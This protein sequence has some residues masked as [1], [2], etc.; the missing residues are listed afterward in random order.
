MPQVL[1]IVVSITYSGLL[2]PEE[3]PHPA[4]QLMHTVSV[5]VIPAIR[6]RKIVPGL[7]QCALARYDDL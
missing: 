7:L 1:H 3:L 6:R 2:A 4:H 5:G